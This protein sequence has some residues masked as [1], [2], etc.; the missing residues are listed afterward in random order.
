MIAQVD[1]LSAHAA[2]GATSLERDDP[3]LVLIHGAG[4]DGTVWQLQTRFLAHRGI[5]ALAVDL[6]AH[7]RSGGEALTTV[8]DMAEWLMRFIETAGFDR[9]HVA[10][11]SMGAFVALQAAADSPERFASLALLGVADA[12]PVH[13]EL[14]RA[15]ADDLP[16]AAALMAAWGHA[17]PS[18]L[19]LNTTPGMWM[20]GGSRALVENS[21]PGAL[22][23]D[24]SACLAFNRAAELASRVT[25]PVTIVVGSSDK[26]TPSRAAR[27]LAQSFTAPTLIELQDAGHMM[28]HE[29]PREVRAILHDAVHLSRHR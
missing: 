7:G 23:A 2:T 18:H 8:A 6:P 26:M 4:M 14:V 1:G 9:V 15:A 16:A 21:R 29:K 22:S 13:P 28:M 24:F 25:C 5:R 10:G 20:I 3:V 17:R 11:H 27:R 12:M 19:G